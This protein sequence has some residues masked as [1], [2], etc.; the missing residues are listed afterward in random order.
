[1]EL[2]STQ[3]FRFPLTSPIVDTETEGSIVIR[4]PNNPGCSDPSA[5][6]ASKDP[7]GLVV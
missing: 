5:V 2:T 3:E 1:M 7:I 4:S 6:K